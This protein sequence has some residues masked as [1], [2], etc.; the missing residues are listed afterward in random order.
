MPS[1]LR[2]SNRRLAHLVAVVDG[3]GNQITSFGGGGGIGGGGTEYTEG[4]I[5]TSFTGPVVLAEGPANTAAPLQVDGSK[6]LLVGIAADT[7]GLATAAR[8]DTAN[9]TLSAIATHV[10]RT[11]R[12]P[13]PFHT[14]TTEA[15]VASGGT[16][17]L[18]SAQVTPGSR[19][20]LLGVVVSSTVPFKAA[21]SALEGGLPAGDP[22]VWVASS[23]G[24]EY[25]PP[26]EGF[27]TVVGSA[28]P[29]LDGFRVAVTNLDTN[30]P[31][32]VYATFLWSEDVI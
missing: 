25:R 9:T 20:H 27:F 2:F 32:D 23:R 17:N 28:D 16:V 29:G 1:V 21:L 13:N 7:V 4:D 22:V 8:Q 12:A 6:R 5:D 3:Q 24:W 11:Y 10:E 30:A 18:E 26:A 15:S 19:G 31:A 14:H